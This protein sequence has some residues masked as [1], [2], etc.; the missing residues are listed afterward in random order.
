LN[1]RKIKKGFF[2][3]FLFIVSSFSIEAQETTNEIN[4]LLHFVKTS[5]VIFIR[6]KKEYDSEKAYEHIKNKYDYFKKKI[7]SAEDFIRLCATQSEMSKKKYVIRKP[8]GKTILCSRWLLD[9]LKAFRI[10]V[11]DD[12]ETLDED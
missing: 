11:I 2:L 10:R 12:L 6:N 7:N 3:I 5:N 9:E 1:F 8:S 4:H